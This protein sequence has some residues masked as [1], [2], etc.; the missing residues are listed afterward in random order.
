[1]RWMGASFSNSDACRRERAEQFGVALVVVVVGLKSQRAGRLD[2][3]E[4][5][6]DEERGRGFEP[7]IAAGDFV[8]RAARL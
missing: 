7:E 2:I 8:N 1:M 3:R 6:V 5:V 4:Q